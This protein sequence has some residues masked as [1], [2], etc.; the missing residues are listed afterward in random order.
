MD[1]RKLLKG[2]LS[3]PLVA[4][5]TPVLAAARTTFMACVDN[6]ALKP[7]SAVAPLSGISAD[8]W[9]RVDLFI[10][11]VRLPN[12]KGQLELQPGRYFIGPDRMAMF[13]LADTRPES[14]PATP[15]NAFNAYTPGIQTQI[16]EK[17]RALAYVDRDGNVVGY[18]WQPRGGAHITASCYAS[19]MTGGAAKKARML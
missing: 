18:A 17:R 16:V 7:V 2:T 15:V 4:T 13:K 14:A 8:E 3:A 12:A 9:L 10:L 6:G 19:V 5:V 11:E 1:R